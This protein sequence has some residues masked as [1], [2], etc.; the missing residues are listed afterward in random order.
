MIFVSATPGP[1]EAK[2]SS[3]VVEQVV[4][5][6]GLIDPEIIVKP[7]KGQIDDLIQQINTRVGSGDRTGPGLA[8]GNSGPGAIDQVLL[9]GLD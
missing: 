7:T 4:R 3:Q 8:G 9:H 6:T 5:P 2:K 1:Y